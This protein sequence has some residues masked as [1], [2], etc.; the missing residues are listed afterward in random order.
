[1]RCHVKCAL[2]DFDCSPSAEAA[3]G[4]EDQSLGRLGL[5]QFALQEGSLEREASSRKELKKVFGECSQ[6]SQSS[7]AECVHDT[8]VMRGA[9][10]NPQGEPGIV[11]VFAIQAFQTLLS[12]PQQP[13]KAAQAPH[14]ALNL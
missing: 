3:S 14:C 4:D 11:F 13:S 9:M 6:C 12:E 2:S 5:V 1:M 7:H 10:P 8:G